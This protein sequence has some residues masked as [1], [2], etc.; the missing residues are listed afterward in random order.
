MVFKKFSFYP[1]TSFSRV[2]SQINF[3]QFSSNSSAFLS[4]PTSRNFKGDDFEF[5]IGV[6]NYVQLHSYFVSNVWALKRSSSVTVSQFSSVLNA[7]LYIR[8]FPRDVSLTPTF[9]N[10]FTSYGVPPQLE[11]I[12]SFIPPEGIKHF[13]GG[14]VKFVLFNKGQVNPTTLL[15]DLRSINASLNYGV[16]KPSDFSQYLDNIKGDYEISSY[17]IVKDE[18]LLFNSFLTS[19]S[20]K[21]L[22]PSSHINENSHTYFAGCLF[23][24]ISESELSN[25]SFELI[26]SSKFV[27]KFKATELDAFCSVC[28]FKLFGRTNPFMGK[29]KS[30]N[31]QSNQQV[32]RTDVPAGS[33]TPSSGFHNF[34]S[35]ID[36]LD[37]K[38]EEIKNLAI[39]LT[40][41]EKGT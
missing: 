6:N 28:Y 23:P 19:E 32:S 7:L 22:L 16:S 31:N 40:N 25:K 34:A 21:M 11:K 10:L 12:I 39:K 1:N 17:Y 37:F 5:I 36:F 20:F 8:L 15:N 33:Q 13:Y 9:I 2:I 29:S 38:V 41:R 24:R 3:R 27:V 26:F 35:R 18:N 14:A 30:T 4:M